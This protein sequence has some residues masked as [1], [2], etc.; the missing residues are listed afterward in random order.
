MSFRWVNTTLSKDFRCEGDRSF[1]P[2][3]EG[4]LGTGMMVERLKQEGTSQSSRSIE[5][6]CKDG[7]QLVS[8]DFQ[9]GG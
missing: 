2:V 7:G 5:D 3:I 8:T 9:A 6:L 1:N 4:F